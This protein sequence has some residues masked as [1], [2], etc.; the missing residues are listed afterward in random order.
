MIIVKTWEE[1]LRFPTAVGFRTNKDAFHVE[2]LDED[3]EVIA[4]VS[5]WRS[6]EKVGAAVDA[7]ADEF[8]AAHAAA[9]KSGGSS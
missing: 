4:L 1:E 8:V 2:L 5:G 7:A 6:V 9:H 3:G